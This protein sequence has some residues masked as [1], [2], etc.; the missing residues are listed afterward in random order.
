MQVLTGIIAGILSV[1]IAYAF[2][3][4]WLIWIAFLLGFNTHYSML[5]AANK[6]KNKVKEIPKTQQKTDR[7]QSR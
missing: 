4:D 3:E 2:E 7:N 1:M 5:I 6:K